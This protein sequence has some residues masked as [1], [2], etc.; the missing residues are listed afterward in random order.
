MKNKYKKNSKKFLRETKEN[1]NR[2]SQPSFLDP[3]IRRSLTKVS[4]KLGFPQNFPVFENKSENC[5]EFVCL[6]LNSFRMKKVLFFKTKS[7]KN[8]LKLQIL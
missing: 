4:T 5:F 7:L 6:N 8:F 1:K 3:L 2:K